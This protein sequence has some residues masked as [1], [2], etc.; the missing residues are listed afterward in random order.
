MSIQPL[1][2]P[3]TS[4]VVTAP[5]EQAS[6]GRTNEANGAKP[7]NLEQAQTQVAKQ[8]ATHEQVQR[9][10]NLVQE[11]V[12]TK[13]NNLAFSVDKDSGKTVVKVIDSQTKEVIKQFPSEEIL[14]LAQ[15]LEQMQ[16]GHGMLLKG[17]A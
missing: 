2:P 10:A 11:F 4:T 14:A 5:V 8:E 6:P 1:G 16:E 17:K 12:Q 13:A 15:A 9:A 3:P 7:A